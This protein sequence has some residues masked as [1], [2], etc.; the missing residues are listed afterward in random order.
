VEPRGNLAVVDTTFAPDY[1][2]HN[3]GP[4]QDVGIEGYNGGGWR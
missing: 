4:G 2:E 3:P 1:S